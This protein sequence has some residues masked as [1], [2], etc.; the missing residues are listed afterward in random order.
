MHTSLDGFV[1]GP[2]GEMNWIHAD[3]ELFDY[4]GQRTNE[5]DLALYGRKTFEMMEGYWPNAG[6]Q[7]NASRHDVQHSAWYN[8]VEKIVMSKTLDAS[9]FKNTKVI[10]ANFAKEIS[11]VKNDVGSEIIIFGSPSAGH[12]LMA[13]NL[14]DEFWVFVNPIVLGEGIPLFKNKKIKLKLLTSKAL[15]SGVVC[16]HYERID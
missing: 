4:A 1:A 3:E 13:E 10:G 16:L 14:I 2:K 8:K 15:N 9:K 7:P 11:Q 6:S 5:A 12:S